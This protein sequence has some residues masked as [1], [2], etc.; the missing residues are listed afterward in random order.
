MTDKDRMR[1]FWHRS[2][3]ASMRVTLYLALRS[4]PDTLIQRAQ[5]GLSTDSP[6][7]IVYT[8]PEGDPITEH[9]GTTDLK[10]PTPPKHT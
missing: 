3:S 6:G 8:L 4:V 9:L 2:S 1:L 7:I 5:T 10:A